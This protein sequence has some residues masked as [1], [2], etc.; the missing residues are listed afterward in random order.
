MIVVIH[1]VDLKMR[2]GVFHV[3]ILVVFRRILARLFH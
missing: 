2:Q 1:V 3:L